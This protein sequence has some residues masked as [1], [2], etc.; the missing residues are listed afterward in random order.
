MSALDI[1]AR[2]R[3]KS[4]AIEVQNAKSYKIIYV[5]VVVMYVIEM[6]SYIFAILYADNHDDTFDW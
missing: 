6:S 1:P 4:I 2:D 5:I 3:S